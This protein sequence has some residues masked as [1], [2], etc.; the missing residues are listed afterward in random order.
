VS[1]PA[2]DSAPPARLLKIGEVARRFGVSTRALRFYEE[3]GLLHRGATTDG[4]FRLYGDDD[5]ARI[6]KILQL[7]GA[8]NFTLDEIRQVIEDDDVLEALR[9]EGRN[10]DD[11]EV[12]LGVVE[13]Y[14]A[15][16]DRQR[17]LVLD[18]RAQLDAYLEEIDAK[19]AR[20]QAA[21]DALVRAP[22]GPT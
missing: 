5:L 22:D 4:G 11:R 6:E 21:R 9:H 15:A 14:L 19:A 3:I 10:T 2:H 7:K 20:I 16:L 12:K 17:R 13:R 18:K 1:E 8:L